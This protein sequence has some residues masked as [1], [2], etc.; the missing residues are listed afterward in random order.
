MA[1]LKTNIQKDH[2]QACLLIPPQGVGRSIAMTMPIDTERMRAISSMLH[3]IFHRNKN[4][5]NTT[6]WWRW[7]SILKRSTLRLLGALEYQPPYNKA[8]PSVDKSM[9]YLAKHVIP[10][11]S[12]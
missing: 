8:S 1:V 4:Q 5:H 11:C 3:L 2:L 6:K 9:E 10:R 7:L 12:L